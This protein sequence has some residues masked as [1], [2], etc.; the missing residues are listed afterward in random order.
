MHILIL[1]TK[2][3]TSNLILK[4]LFVFII[5]VCTQ[6]CCV[7]SVI[8]IIPTQLFFCN[9]CV[10]LV[11]DWTSCAI[12]ALRAGRVLWPSKVAK[13][14]TWE[15]LTSARTL[16]QPTPVVMVTGLCQHLCIDQAQGSVPFLQPCVCERERERER[17]GGR[18]SRQWHLQHFHTG[19]TVS[20]LYIFHSTFEVTDK[21]SIYLINIA[22]KKEL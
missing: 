12:L 16:C 7:L 10:A 5:A 1:Y 11:P 17:E 18:L 22:G 3:K 19:H 15:P 4:L 21:S 6:E 9:I 13:C 14:V 20:S 2:S 8:I